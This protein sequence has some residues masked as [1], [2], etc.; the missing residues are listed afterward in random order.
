LKSSFAN[1]NAAIDADTNVISV[2]STETKALFSIDLP[3]GN[4]VKILTYDYAVGSL[5]IHSI[6]MAVNAPRVLKDV[7]TIQKN[8]TIIIIPSNIVNT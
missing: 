6:G 3:K 2:Y 4:S 8:G 7:E 1:A 5:G